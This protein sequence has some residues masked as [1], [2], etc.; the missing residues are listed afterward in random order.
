MHYKLTYV[1]AATFA[2]I[3]GWAGTINA[4]SD[5]GRDTSPRQAKTVIVH[6]EPSDFPESF[7][8]TEYKDIRIEKSIRVPMRDGVRLSTDLYFPVGAPEPLPV[9]QIRLPYNKKRYMRFREPGSV[10]HFFAGHGYVVAIQ[11]MRG[12]YESEG[13]Y[14]VSAADREDGYD[15]VDWLSNQPWSNGK[16][17]TYGCSYLGEN[18]IQLAATRHPNHAA[19]IPQAAGG[20]YR[21]TFRQFAAM[22]GGS[23]ELATS[24]GWFYGAGSKLFFRPPEAMTEEQFRKFAAYY[25]PAPQMPQIDF[26]KFFWT[27]PIID[28]LQ[29][30]GSGPTDYE[31]F[32]SHA[33]LDPYWD[34]LNYVHDD[35]RFNVPALHVNSWYDGAVKET[36]ILFNLF[37]KNAETAKAR[38]NQFLIISPTAHCLSE[39]TTEATKVGELNLGDARLDYYRIYLD[40]FDHWLK[41]IENGI[42][43]MPKIRYYQMGANEWRTA[44]KWPIPGTQF[45]K[46]YLHSDGQANTKIGTGTLNGQPPDEEPPDRYTYDP[47][48]PVP[49]VGGPI[50]CISSDAA[51]AG[52]YEQSRVEIRKDVLVYTSEVFQEP[53]YVTGPIEAILYV[54]S[55][56]KDTDFTVKLVDVHPDG[57]AYN[58]QEAIQR[59]RYREGYD[60]KVLMEEGVIYEVRLNLHATSNR[61]GAGHRVRLEV[62]SSNFPRF[63]RNL[64]TG[65]NNYDESDPVV[66]QNTIHHS[67]RYASH[68]VLPIVPKE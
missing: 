43:Q 39:R 60:K 20:A 17:G 15:T 36:L 5:T 65:G 53:L 12:R 45:A 64:N 10:A 13:E 56:A 55:S 31:D 9:V 58:I 37:Q 33:P 40:W 2:L 8:R 50:C 59:A 25:D 3:L 66:A 23:I 1:G 35:D 16:V 67:G 32:V 19:A 46:Y 24:L 44:E 26:T 47:K 27:L 11:D 62:S 41:G 48:T 68:I 34:K 30:A 49:S 14:L 18:Q 52:A 57:T 42:T 22:Q 51:P 21:G 7:P 28:L 6:S 4:S 61:F 29:K 63:D 54:S 38:D